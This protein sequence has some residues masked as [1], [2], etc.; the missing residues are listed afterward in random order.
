MSGSKPQYTREQY[1]EAIRKSTGNLSVAA[2]LLGCSRQT[3][4]NAVARW[5]TVAAVVSQQREKVVDL[6]EQKLIEKLKASEWPAI[7]YTLSTLGKAR[8]YGPEVE[9]VTSVEFI[10]KYDKS[11][12]RNQSEEAAS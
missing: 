7:K 4:Y 8:G 1:I 10:V 12:D 6:A 5:K 2:K 9:P 3:V 11:P